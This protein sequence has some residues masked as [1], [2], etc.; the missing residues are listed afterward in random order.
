MCD[1]R[2][3][4]DMISYKYTCQGFYTHGT[5]DPQEVIFINE[6]EDRNSKHIYEIIKARKSSI[7]NQICIN[8]S[9][10]AKMRRSSQKSD[11]VIFQSG[12]T[13]DLFGLKVKY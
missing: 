2:K 10:L 4:C 1:V 5:I 8:P 3:Y 13:L 6:V 9:F 11:R 7:I 12:F